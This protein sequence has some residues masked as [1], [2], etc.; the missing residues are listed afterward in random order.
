[1]EQTLTLNVYELLSIFACG[2]LFYF[3]CEG[4]GHIIVWL[5]EIALKAIKERKKNV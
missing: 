4:I 1:M 3:L 5:F 2:G